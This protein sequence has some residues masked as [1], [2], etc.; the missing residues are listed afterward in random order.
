[1]QLDDMLLFSV[2]DHVIEPR[3]IFDGREPAEYAGRFPRLL[4][5]ENDIEAWRNVLYYCCFLQTKA[6]V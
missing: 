5:D 6:Y 4:P 2:D 3:D 1:M